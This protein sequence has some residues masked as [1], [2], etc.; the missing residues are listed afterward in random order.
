[1]K[2]KHQVIKP[3]PVTRQKNS[4]VKN[5]Y[6]LFCLADASHC[7]PLCSAPR[8]RMKARGDDVKPLWKPGMTFGELKHFMSSEGCA[9]TRSL[10]SLLYGK[11]VKL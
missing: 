3:T 11:V 10:F 9:I 1:M 7:Q 6:L 5:W 2:Q 8:T 4:L